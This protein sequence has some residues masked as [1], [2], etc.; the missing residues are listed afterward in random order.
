MEW[1]M[2]R[3]RCIKFAVFIV[4]AVTFYGCKSKQEAPGTSS[5][6]PRQ[7]T[8]EIKSISGQNAA[9]G[10]VTSPKDKEDAEA[11][12]ARVLAQLEAG[13]FA[14]IYKAAAPGFKQIGSEAQFV[15]KFQ[16]TRKTTGPLKN[17]HEISFDTL[18]DTSNVIN[19][20]LENEQFTSIYRLTFARSRGGKM[21]LIGLNQHYESQKKPLPK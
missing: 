3:V 11:A 9:G 17:A 14:A 16:Q 5:V 8:G 10:V 12:A 19:Y 20:H 6:A 4:A 2:N 18:P 1:A 7:N 13:N 21:E 15:E